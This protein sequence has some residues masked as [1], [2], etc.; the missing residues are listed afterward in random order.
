MFEQTL[1]LVQTSEDVATLR[2]EIEELRRGLYRVGKKGTQETLSHVLNTAV[3]AHVAEALKI[4]LKQSGKGVEEFLDG[5][6]EVLGKL[7]SV[8]LTL[9]FEPTRETI[10]RL[11]TWFKREVGSDLVLGLTHDPNILGGIQL[12]TPEG[13]FYD[14]SVA[15]KIDGILQESK[16]EILQHLKRKVGEQ[17]REGNQVTEI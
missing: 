2:Q 13:R 14:L 11:T 10:A 3:R 9:A 7:K 12:A 1:R 8:R 5:L 4:D 15:G 17:K 6:E 16:T